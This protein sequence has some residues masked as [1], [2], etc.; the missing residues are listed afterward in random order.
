LISLANKEAQTENNKGEINKKATWA[1]ERPS[2]VGLE[3]I[4]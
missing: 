3:K 4:K 1:Y 2:K